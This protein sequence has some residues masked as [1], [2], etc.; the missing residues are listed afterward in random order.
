MKPGEN[1]PVCAGAELTDPRHIPMHMAGARYRIAGYYCMRCGIGLDGQSRKLS[2]QMLR[3]LADLRR[4]V[5]Q[6]APVVRR[7]NMA[8]RIKPVPGYAQRLCAL[9]RGLRGD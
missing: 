2:D 7:R 1:L 8:P 6:H 9:M 5:A 3:G 4:L